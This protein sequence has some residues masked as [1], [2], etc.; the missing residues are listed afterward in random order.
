MAEFFELT[1]ITK[2]KVD[3]SKW[4]NKFGLIL[5]K[6]YYTGSLNFFHGNELLI[7]EYQHN[8]LWEY[9]FSLDCERLFTR[10]NIFNKIIILL[11]NL[12]DIFNIDTFEYAIGNI[13]TSSDLVKNDIGSSSLSNEIILKSSLIFIPLNTLVE[14]EISLFHI[15]FKSDKIACLF[16]PTSGILYSAKADKYKI[17]KESYKL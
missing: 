10:E 4:K 17:L 7:Y 16:N 13:E 11:G 15:V 1:I 5:G 3:F 14:I 2:Q 8:N 9:E 12:E 6:E